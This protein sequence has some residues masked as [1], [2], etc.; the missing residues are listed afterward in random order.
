MVK[1][2]NLF[3]NMSILILNH[4]KY[5]QAAGLRLFVIKAGMRTSKA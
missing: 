1:I 5:F 2:I 3:M 4:K